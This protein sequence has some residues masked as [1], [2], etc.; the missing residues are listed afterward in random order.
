MSGN[1]KEFKQNP[2]KVSVLNV[3]YETKN[4][5]LKKSHFLEEEMCVCLHDRMNKINTD[6][7]NIRIYHSC[8]LWTEKSFVRDY[9]LH[10]TTCQV[11][12]AE[13]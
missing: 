7:K 13:Q 9:V 8:L 4:K 11:Y 2:E 10:H 5:L 12:N 3:V 6:L 1:V